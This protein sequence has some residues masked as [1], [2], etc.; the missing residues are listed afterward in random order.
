M[1][2]GISAKTIWNDAARTGLMLG[3]VTVALQALAQLVTGLIDNAI[4]KGLSEFFLWAVKFVACILLMRMFLKNFIK[5]HPEAINKDTRH[6]GEA[7][8][9][10]SAFIVAAYTLV[11]YLYINPDV[12]RESMDM[13]R[14]SYSSFMTGS[15][16]DEIENAM[17]DL[18][19]I[20]F[21]TVFIYCSLYGTLLSGILSNNI[22]ARRSIFDE[23]DED[24]Q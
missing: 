7:I 1:S 20:S 2:E 6:Y 23:P 10:L 4:L 5:A 3:I 11:Y 24:E 22:P 13:I 16:I 19:V 21:F 14:E 12:V 15:Q 17:A 9:V 18:P 8:A